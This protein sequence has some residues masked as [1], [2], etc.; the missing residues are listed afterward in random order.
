MGILD[1]YAWQPGAIK[2]V[3]I[4]EMPNA[5]HVVSNRHAYTRNQFVRFSSGAYKGDIAQVL[6][7][8]DNGSTILVR[9]VPRINIPMATATVEQR[10]KLRAEGKGGRAP[11]RLWDRVA[12]E[13]ALQQSGSAATIDVSARST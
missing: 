9:H 10:K 5:L 4:V 8:I 2:Q 7:L 12:I 13:T 11:P 6:D 3:P 1:L